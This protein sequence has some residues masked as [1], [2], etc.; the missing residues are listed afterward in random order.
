[1][2]TTERVLIA[3]FVAV[4]TMGLS[5]CKQDAKAAWNDI[6]KKC[7][8]SDLNGS[9]V[10]YFGPSNN[11]GPGSIW[12]VPEGGGYRLRW[13]LGDMPGSEVALLPGNEVSCAG[14]AKTDF[15]GKASAGLLTSVTPASG[16]AAV[17]FGRA[18]KITANADSLS[19]DILKEGPFEQYVRELPATSSIKQELGTNTRLVAVRALRVKGFSAELEFSA[20][21]AASLKAK[22]QGQLPAQLTGELNLGLEGTWVNETTLKIAAKDFYIAGELGKYEAAGFA[23]ADNPVSDAVDIKDGNKLGREKP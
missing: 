14:V 22:Y 18:R 2:R 19:W 9:K 23:A 7:A 5:G 12:R 4:I 8:K 21:Q 17:E 3:T 16:E 1:M 6:V 10:L 13:T 15:S 11:V 20:S